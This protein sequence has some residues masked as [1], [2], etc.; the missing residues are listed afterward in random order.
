VSSAFA[1]L[2]E[3]SHIGWRASRKARSL[4]KDRTRK[5][6]ARGLERAVAD[7]DSGR[8]AVGAAIPIQRRAVLACRVELLEL[9]ARLLA[10][11][12]VYAQGVEMTQR[13]LTNPLSPLYQTGG[14]LHTLV[15]D[16]SAALDGH[17]E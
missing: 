1:L 16:A 8:R 4:T 3:S 6:L 10:P 11:Q 13:L 12:P 2:G 14:D 7:A 15:T 17:L 9:A 5:R